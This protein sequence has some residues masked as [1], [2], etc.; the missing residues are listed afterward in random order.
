MGAHEKKEF[1]LTSQFPRSDWGDGHK[2]GSS[3]RLPAISSDKFFS[4]LCRRAVHRS[5]EHLLSNN[6]QRQHSSISVS[7]CHHGSRFHVLKHVLKHVLSAQNKAIQEGHCN[8]LP[9]QAIDPMVQGQ[10][11]RDVWMAHVVHRVVNV[12][13]VLIAGN[14]HARKDAGVM[15]WLTPQ[16]QAK[17]QVHG[18]VESV[19]QNDAIGYDHVHVMSRVER[20]DPCLAFAQKPVKK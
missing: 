17:T 10:I 14:G 5:S 11:A 8:M 7:L 18:Y 20:D 6:E 3:T 2:L 16:N 12:L 1:A 9:V 19:D 4:V 15:Q 13:V